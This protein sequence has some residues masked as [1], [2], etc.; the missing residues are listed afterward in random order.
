MSPEPWQLTLETASVEET[1]EV[2]E[3]MGRRLKGGEV[4]ALEGSLGAGK[5]ALIRGLARGLGI[6]DH[7]IS[8]PTFVFLHEHHGRLPLA[9]LDLFRIGSP[10]DLPDLGIQDYLESPWV[11]AVEWAERAP[12][13]LPE[14]RLTIRMSET[15]NQHHRRLV[16]HTSNPCYE[17]VFSELKVAFCAFTSNR[18]ER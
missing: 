15:Q 18:R 8:S 12:W 13:Y 4:I 3:I 5:T 7:E 10:S 9:H 14:D 17:A 2:G 1:E 11:V 6:K 16:L